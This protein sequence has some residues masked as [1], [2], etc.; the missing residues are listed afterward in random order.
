MTSS[1][2]SK[3]PGTSLRV[4]GYYDQFDLRKIV[5][6]REFLRAIDKEHKMQH[7]DVVVYTNK[8]LTRFRLVLKIQGFLVQCVPEIDD[9]DEV[10]L[11]LKIN[12]TLAGLSAS[13]KLYVKIVKTGNQVTGED[14]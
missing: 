14:G 9:Q 4:V 3:S 11:Y 1:G 6:R 12:E 7:L 13:E 5:S 8:R 2:F 10:S